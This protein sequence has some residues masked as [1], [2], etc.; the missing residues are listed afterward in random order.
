MIVG[1]EHS[2]GPVRGPGRSFSQSDSQSVSSLLLLKL[3]RSVGER[4]P[5][6]KV[7]PNCRMLG[8]RCVSPRLLNDSCQGGLNAEPHWAHR[9]GLLLG[10]K[11]L[12]RCHTFTYCVFGKLRNAVQFQLVHDSFAM[13][14]DGF[15]A[16]VKRRSHLLSGFAFDQE[17]QH[18]SF[19]ARGFAAH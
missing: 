14:F 17:L 10:S 13:G 5:G 1:N 6:Y 15:G 2:P 18:L 4:T 11:G 8:S 12:W 19:P 7:T 16:H 3:N 9:R